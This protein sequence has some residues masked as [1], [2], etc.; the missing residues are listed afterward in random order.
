MRTIYIKSNIPYN[1]INDILF[2]LKKK[3]IIFFIDLQSVCKGLYNKNNIFNEINYYV[4]NDQPSDLLINEYRDYLNNL[5]L[6]FKYFNPFMVTFYD[7]GHNSQNV[8]I[9]NSYKGGRSKLKEIIES[10][11]EMLLYRRIKKRY[12]EEIEKRF[13]VEN[14]G[15]VYYLKEYESDLIPHYIIKNNIFNSND[16]TTLNVILSN[17]KDLL[18]CCQFLNTIQITNTYVPT[19]T[20]SKLKIECWDNKNAIIYLYRN[21][22]PGTITSKHIPLILALAGDKADNIKGI[23]GI[24]YKKAIDLVQNFKIPFDPIELENC[25]DDMPNIINENLDMIQNNM[26]MISFDEQIKRIDT[27]KL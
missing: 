21:F 26:R 9:N 19:A 24:G 15:K 7:D 17:D 16:K 10:D 3:K 13:T 12:Y 23:K 8:S 4:Q 18:Q 1:L 25:K 2:K 22:K 27:T 11:D 5:Y 14:R 6:K 20:K